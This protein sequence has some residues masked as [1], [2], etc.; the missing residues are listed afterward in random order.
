[1]K[2]IRTVNGVIVQDVNH[3]YVCQKVIPYHGI[4]RYSSWPLSNRVDELSK[5]LT[6]EMEERWFNYYSGE[7]FA[8]AAVPSPEFTR[9]YLNL[10]S[11]LKIK[12]RILLIETN[13]KNPRW[14]CSNINTIILGYEYATSQDLFSALYDD[15]FGN[16]TVFTL[17]KYKNMLNHHGLF[18]NENDLVAYIRDRNKAILEGYNLESHGDFCMFKISIIPEFY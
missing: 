1:M 16:E 10:C 15:L 7:E 6:R 3:F 11:Q 14:E 18:D 9:K 12:T 2:Y 8:L 17:K 13:R 5:K 4:A